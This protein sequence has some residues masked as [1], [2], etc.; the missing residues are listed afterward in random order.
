MNV[1]CASDSEHGRVSA[2]ASADRLVSNG[3]TSCSRP[4]TTRFAVVSSHKNLSIAYSCVELI[5]IYCLFA[6]ASTDKRQS[7]PVLVFERLG[8]N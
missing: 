1:R 2:A 5:G 4:S 7:Q 3:R 6:C 8:E